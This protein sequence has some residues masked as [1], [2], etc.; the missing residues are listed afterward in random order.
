MFRVTGSFSGLPPCWFR[1]SMRGVEA[2]VVVELERRSLDLVGPGLGH[3]RHGGAAGHALLGVEVVRRHVDRVDRLGGSN[4]HQVV[5]QP[6]VDVRGAIRAGG[7]LIRALPVHVGRQRPRRRVGLGVVEPRRGRTG[8]QV[9]ERL[10]IAELV[11]R[12]RR[13][14]GGFQL[15]RDV[16]LVGLQQLGCRLDVHHFGEGADLESEVHT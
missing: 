3:D 15:G 12:H 2:L 8:H 1:R 14:L 6:D 11:E 5:R 4:I 13:D 10:V 16:G 9:E 7:V